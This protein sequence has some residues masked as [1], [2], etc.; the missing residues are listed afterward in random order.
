MIFNI[1]NINKTSISANLIFAGYPVL[2]GKLFYTDTK[3][4]RLF[5]YVAV[6]RIAVPLV[7]SKKRVEK[8]Q[9][10]CLF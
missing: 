3:N 1:L 9:S 6:N 2:V 7:E 10:K 5:C 8:W 4:Q